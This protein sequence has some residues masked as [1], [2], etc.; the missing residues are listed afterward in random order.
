MTLEAFGDLLRAKVG[1]LGPLLYCIPYS[2]AAWL[3]SRIDG[4]RPCYR[5]IVTGSTFLV[6]SLI[7]NLIFGVYKSPVLRHAKEQQFLAVTSPKSE[8]CK[9]D[10]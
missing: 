3:L 8:V 6:N 7:F 1:S 5:V 10:G 9:V 2:Y 4:A